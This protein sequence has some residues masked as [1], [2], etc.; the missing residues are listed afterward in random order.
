MSSFVASAIGAPFIRRGRHASDIAY[1]Y[2][3]GLEVRGYE[4]FYR[5]RL[6]A[7]F[8]P[9]NHGEV[10]VFV[11]A[12]R[13][14]LPPGSYLSALAAAGPD[15][16]DRLAVAAAPARVQRFGGI[17]GFIRRA[18]GPGWALVGDAGY[19]KDPLSTH[20]LTDA[21]R[22]AELL[23][24]AVLRGNLDEYQ[25]QRDAL[26]RQLFAVVD[27]LASYDWDEPAVRRLLLALNSCMADEV[28]ALLGLGESSADIAASPAW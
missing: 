2:W 26:S 25:L 8:I 24:R 19:F 14:S 9:T 13:G 12:P 18:V 5:P 16:H 4:W 15:A 21:L 7:G 28:E 20:G 22:D 23:A 1:G 6:T 17:P 10:C 27:D 11:G 3:T